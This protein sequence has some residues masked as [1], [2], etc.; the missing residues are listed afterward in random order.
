MTRQLLSELERVKVLFQAR[1]IALHLGAKPPE[2]LPPE[3]PSSYK[4][5]DSGHDKD[6]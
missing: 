2:T 3:E 5:K 6:R 4:D 1:A